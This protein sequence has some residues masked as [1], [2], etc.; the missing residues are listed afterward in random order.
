MNMDEMEVEQSWDCHDHW[1]QVEPSPFRV[2]CQDILLFCIE[3]H[4]QAKKLIDD[5]TQ[6]WP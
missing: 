5:I 2:V 6:V 1:D 3:Y 4:E